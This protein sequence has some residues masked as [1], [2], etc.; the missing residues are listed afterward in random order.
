[1]GVAYLSDRSQ[2]R[3]L[4]IVLFGCISIVGYGILISDS[5]AGV[6]YFGCFL[7]ALG[8][9]VAVGMPLAWVSPILSSY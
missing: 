1:M 8:L 4:F 9:Y 6:H 7:V 5:P 3:G 2:K